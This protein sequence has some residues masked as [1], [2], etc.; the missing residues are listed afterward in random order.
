MQFP[1]R[2]Y[3]YVGGVRLQHSG[4][5]DFRCFPEPLILSFLVEAIQNRLSMQ[6]S[7]F[8]TQAVSRI[9]LGTRLWNNHVSLVPRPRGLPDL[10]TRLLLLQLL[11]LQHVSLIPRPMWTARPGN[12]AS[13]SCNYFCFSTLAS[14]PGHVDCPTWEQGYSCNYFCFSTLASFPG[15]HSHAYYNNTCSWLIFSLLH[16]IQTTY[17][18]W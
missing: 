11:L 14:F 18:N 16:S 10:G 4:R 7:S 8:Q 3:T 5:G 17:Y 13:N 1:P 15:S 9:H 12:K 6:I 2:K